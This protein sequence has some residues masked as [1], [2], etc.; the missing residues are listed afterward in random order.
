MENI[1]F[2]EICKKCAECCKN[3]PYVKLYQ[4]EISKL[5]KLTGLP[6][7]VFASP[8]G[9]APEEYFM[10]FKENGDCFFLNENNGDY[11]CIAYEARSEI[12]R[13]YPSSPIENKV[14]DANREMILRSNSG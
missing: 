3:F 2:S 11:S 1:I 12:C 7:D 5:E 10:Q 14:C 6:F 4:D 8:K 9:G 13:K